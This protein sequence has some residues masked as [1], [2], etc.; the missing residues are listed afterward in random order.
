MKHKDL[1]R[2]H[3][4]PKF[5]SRWLKETSATGF[6]RG[7]EF[8]EK[9]IQDLPRLPLLCGDCE[10]LFS[11][12]E[13]YFA[14][15]VFHPVLND[16]KEEIEYDENLRRFILSL[17]WR[18]L[19]TGRSIQV[20]QDPW[21][22]EYV[23][24]AEK[25]WREYLLNEMSN[26]VPYEHHMSFIGFA[27]NDTQI[28]RKFQW[29]SLRGT[30]STLA[31]NKNTIFAFTH[32]PRFFFVSTIHP[33]TFP[34]WNITKIENKGKFAIKAQIN[35]R[36]FWDFLIS[37]GRLVSSSIKGSDQGRITRSV[38][39]E[40]EKFLKSESLAVMIDESRRQRLKKIKD[41]PRG[42]RMLIDIIDRSVENPELTSLQQSWA[43]YLR[44]VVANEL[45]YIQLGKATMADALIQS[46][47]IQADEK[48]RH[49]Q[50]HFETQQLIIGFMVT[51]CDTKAEQIKLLHEALD[52]LV[53]KKDSR[54]ERIIVVF[55]VNPLDEEMPYETMYYAG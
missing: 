44:H 36:Y 21:I 10:Q 37:R 48:H 34:D 30:D 20:R 32:L 52:T 50:C 19:V 14:E 17:N 4:I 54:D 27:D 13:V 28:P 8:P 41:L 9:R 47:I 24:K 7:V 1:K 39:R 2:S 12:L 25:A 5:V 49:A 23:E 40:P 33:L 43:R 3:I 18:T 53:K 38:E 11:K 42:I 55:S 35:D 26:S 16:R 45:S 15:E 46:T 22:K 51:I 31:S 29:Y 6:L